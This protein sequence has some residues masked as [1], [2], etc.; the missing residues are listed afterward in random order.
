[1]LYNF[2]LILTNINLD[3]SV[4]IKNLFYTL[5]LISFS[6]QT[7]F[8]QQGK[9]DSSFNVF[10]DGQIGDGFDN[11]LRT[12]LMLKDGTLLV[13]GDYLSL[14]GTPASYLTRLNPDGSID[15]SFNIGTGFNGKI[16]A[17]YLQS[18]GKI[19]LGGNFT[20]FNGINAGRIIRLNVDGSYDETFN[21]TIGAT[22]GI[23]Y[24]IDS[25][26]D[27]KIIIVGSFT[28]YNNTTV[29]R[30]ARLLPNGLLDST[31]LTG[32]GSA[33]NITHAKVLSDQKVLL[34]GNFIAFNGTSANHII[35]LNSNGTFDST[36]NCGVGF[37]DN[38]NAIALQSDGKMVLGGN[39]TLFNDTV[40][41]RII[42][43]NE[44]GTKDENFLIGTGFSR[45]GVQTIKIN[46]NG[47]IMV[48]GSFVGFYNT[49]EVTRLIFLQPDGSIKPNFD[50]GSGP[51]SASVLA[52][53][54]DEEGSWFVGGSFSVFN[55]QNQGRLVKISTEGEQDI[56]YLVSGIGFDN[57]VLTILPL[58]NKKA[59]IGGNF[60][61]FN[62]ETAS[63][64]TCLLENGKIDPVFNITNV[65]S[66][67]LIKTSGLQTDGKIILGG[68]FTKYN[69]L[70]NN[71]IVRI[72]PNGEIDGSFGSGDGFNAQ[73]YALAVQ[74]DQ[75]IIVGGAFTKYNGS[76][77]N[78]GRI[79]RIL[80]DGTKDPD[81]IT[82]FGADG[83]IESIVVQ[84]DGKILVGGHFKKF[85]D[86]PSAGLVRLNSNGSIDENFGIGNGFDKYVYAIALQSDQKILVGGSFLTFNGTSQKRIIRLNIDGSFDRTFDVGAGFS[87][88]DVRAILVQPDSRI[89]VGGT[90]SGTYNTLP[91]SRLIRLLSS[92]SYDN[93][94][95]A[96]LNN[97]LYAMNFTED[98]KLV[99]GGN[100]NSISGISKH[101]I[102]R[103]KLCVNKT[104]WDGISWSNGYP[105]AGK[106]VYFEESFPSLTTTNICG[107]NIEKGKTVTLL[108]KQTLGIEFS[109]TGSGILV[110]EDSASLYQDDDDMVNTGIVHVK[111]KTKPVIRFDLTYWSSPV[112]DVKLYDFSPE[113]LF[114]KYFWYDP[115]LGWKTNLN[116]TMT[117]T[118]GN[119]YSIRAPQS[120]S[121]AERATFEGVFKGIPNNG[122]IE[123][124]FVAADRFY[125]VGNPYPCAISAD[126]FLIENTPKTKGA[127]YFWTHNTP[128]RITI[129][130]TNTYRYTND[131]FAVYNLLGGVGTR[132]ALSSGANND[133][134]DGKIASGQAFFVKSTQKGYLEFNNSMRIRDNNNSFFRPAL[135]SEIKSI[136][137]KHRFWLNVKSDNEF[138]QILLGY[139][140]GASNALDL[141]YDA[142]YLS[143]GATLDFYSISENKK[144]VIQGRELPFLESDSISLGYKTTI[145]DN[146]EFEID[147]QDIFFN[148]KSI[149]LVDKNL[150][151][152]H[153]L[154]LE[155]YKF[156]SEVGT[157]N[158][159]FIIIF[160]NS[161]LD[162]NVFEKEENGIVISIRNKI[163]TVDSVNY[164]LK[165]VSVFDISG[166]CLYKKEKLE[167]KKAFIENLF[168]SHQVLI[169]KVVCENGN[170]TS[171]KII[172]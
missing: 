92:G 147:H 43:L 110:L 145:R 65:G 87:K 168:S 152:I 77:V 169:I 101:R 98:Y 118:L 140:A 80:P 126:D 105:S 163:I 73:V 16:Y 171:R 144:L 35:R 75:K 34:T 52:L 164:N 162:S 19:I 55:S 63:K 119:G 170:L 49:T 113:T 150:N 102:A 67:G 2:N 54:F 143:S 31:F 22:T 33:L 138:K 64:I 48:G 15:E 108:E 135:N 125:L 172:F 95:T 4:L 3:Y 10:D 7:I 133:A 97:T 115:I 61:K 96:S 51:A 112:A 114:D 94:F 106:D 5:I 88:G 130:G 29:N 68:N 160:S 14:N 25:Q 131:D 120:F 39:F 155:P 104:I 44:D 85:N 37:N 53:E 82:G 76:P 159:R 91:S 45:E 149:F 32:S 123:V 62:G 8:S 146:F 46:K 69:D 122:K 38:V 166:K 86:V 81:F 90:F 72:F 154:S 26:S 151:K 11:T 18:D 12:L 59:I 57:S 161:T 167:T 136:Q 9:V 111:R 79:I 156:D 99:I 17:S 128:P 24:D 47:E 20:S 165:E 116:G 78:A 107:C 134:P 28:K 121:T 89:L 157:F 132:S 124:E 27:G 6:V 60:K 58:L 93:T 56:S 23:V 42:R 84:L 117:M 139:A 158:D 141:N 103:L 74:S 41:N 100:F 83:I 21:T 30:V 153:N 109:Y 127:L 66:N 129:P 148:N 70:I 50:I 71:R 36:F 40:A 1:M 13:G 137:E 142:E